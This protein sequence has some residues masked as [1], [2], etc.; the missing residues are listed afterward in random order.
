MRYLK[1]GRDLA[2]R[3]ARVG[4]R[5]TWRANLALAALTMIGVLLAVD[6]GIRVKMP[7][8]E[9]G[10]GAWAAYPGSRLEMISRPDGVREVHS[11][12]RY[13]FRGDDFQLHAGAAPRIVAIGDS[14][15]EGSGVQFDE[16]WPKV[17]EKL[18]NASGHRIEVLNLGDGG[19]P[20]A[21][22]AEI[23][24]KV[25]MAL[26]P[27]YVIVCL[28]SSDFRLGLSLP[29]DLDVRTDLPDPFRDE[30]RGWQRLA[31]RLLPGWIYLVERARGLWPLQEGPIWL[32]YTD[33]WT[34]QAAK[35]V[36]K[37]EALSL[38]DALALVEERLAAIDPAIVEAARLREFNPDSVRQALIQPW[39]YKVTVDD[40]EV[41]AEDLAWQTREW[42]AWFSAVTKKR[43]V[44]PWI[45]Y[46]PKATLVA[47]GPWG[48]IEETLFEVPD[49][50]GDTSIRD[51][52]REQ[53]DAAG[54]P[55]IDGTPILKA[56]AGRNLFL[57]YDTHPTAN[58]HRLIAVEAHRRLEPV[59]ARHAR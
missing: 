37:R 35:Q 48:M 30:R 5:G 49:V 52:L 36:A 4:I 32:A 18:L 58:A 38:R 47:D 8:P 59:L 55:M 23:L 44:E 24:A 21:R 25:G 2:R 29:Q 45:L 11:Y 39:S 46:F 13:G 20:P 3:S 42:L 12:N 34:E 19:S 53:T 33:R 56:Q 9:K 6:A 50:L 14:Y 22:Y 54:V 26:E 7:V 43:G 15:T 27:R 57:R 51:L 16:T 10:Y 41:S 17:L 28:N 31:V 1:R 40:M